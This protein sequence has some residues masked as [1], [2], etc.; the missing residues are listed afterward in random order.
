MMNIHQAIEDLYRNKVYSNT[1]NK[2][3]LKQVPAEAKTVLDVGCGAGDNASILKALHKKVTGITIS[4]AEAK[5]VSDI[6]DKVM[7]INIE[8][9]VSLVLDKFDVIILSHVCE[10]LRYPTLILKNLA[11]NLAKNGIMIVAVPNMAF[12][13]NRWKLLKGDWQMM[14]SGPF[15]K[16][17]LKFFSYLTANTLCD[18][19]RLKVG[20]KIPSLLALPLWPL[21]LILPRFCKQLDKIIGNW[22]PNLFARQTIL[23]LEHNDNLCQDL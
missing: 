6:C 9:Q 19:K 20:K 13:R 2:D 18:E 5:L 8:E 14:E 15:D 7:V 10:H 21:R 16:T 11:N 4:E 23:I 17:H 3:V 12:Y 22:F 1:G